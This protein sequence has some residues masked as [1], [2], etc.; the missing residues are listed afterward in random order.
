MNR[1]EFLQKV[2]FGAAIALV[3]ACVGGLAT[4]CSSENP[5]VTAP[6]NVNFTIDVSTGA[7]SANGGFLVINGI[8]IARTIS[9][10]FI[11]VSSACTHQ[12]T[13]IN[14]NS[15]NNNFVCPNHGAHFDS[16]GAV[17]Q[18][19][20]AVNLTSYHTQLTGNTLN[21]YS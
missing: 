12:G 9:G 10:A 8:I 13:T 1:K 11:A 20:A 5:T 17:T 19:P 18:G 14:Y 15:T 16:S 4:S 7:L 3:P 21:V 2:G 6:K